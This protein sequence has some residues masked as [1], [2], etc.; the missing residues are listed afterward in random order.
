M[1]AIGFA[2][3]MERLISLVPHSKVSENFLY[4]A[5]MGDEAQRQGMALARFLRQNDIE[6]WMEYKERSLRNQ[7][8]RANKLGASW[9]LIVGEEEIKSRKY[10]LK[11]MS[12]GKQVEVSQEDIIKV[13]REFS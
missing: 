10:Q 2:V 6:C 12:T 7:M 1:C 11:N 8:S 9:V 3:G 5:F 4:L 13:I